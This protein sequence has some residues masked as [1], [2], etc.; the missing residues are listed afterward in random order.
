MPAKKIKKEIYRFIVKFE[1]NVVNLSH[2]LKTKFF[3]EF[4]KN[5]PYHVQ[6][7]MNFVPFDFFGWSDIWK[8]YY[9]NNHQ[10]IKIKKEN[11]KANL[12]EDSKEIVD[13]ITERNFFLVPLK[14]FEKYV[15]FNKF[16]IFSQEELMEQTKDINI[17][18][19]KSKYKLSDGNYTKTVFQYKNGLCFIPQ[20][21]VK[22]LKSKDFIDGGALMGDSA[23]IF[24]DFSPN[25]IYSFEPIKYNYGLLQQTIQL[26]NLENVICPVNLGL[27]DKEEE[28][29]LHGSWGSASVHQI[30]DH[31]N[32]VHETI[33]TTTIDKFVQ[34]NNLNLGLIK[35]DIEGNELNTIKGATNSIEKFKPILLISIYHTPNDF[36]EIK[37]LIENLNLGYKFLIKKL[38]PNDLTNEV[39]LI[40]YAE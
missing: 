11:L 5:E 22:A 8:K 16:Q 15:L 36:F 38:K 3:N 34:E 4:F 24:N 7:K 21:N 19:V 1:K 9:L 31:H 10:D 13:I 17:E 18:E 28:I 39:M 14:K 27:S 26:N 35:L 25:K 40:S 20:K 33:R 6:K 37:P 2:Y 12:P 32:K 23:L 29:Q 30:S